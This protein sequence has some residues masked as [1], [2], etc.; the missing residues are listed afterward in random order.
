MRKVKQWVAALLLVALSMSNC[1]AASAESLPADTPTDSL[2]VSTAESM[3]PEKPEQETDAQSESSE[4]AQKTTTQSA[5]I[6][7]SVPAAGATYAVVIPE[8]L[9]LGTLDA[10]Q[11]FQQD[12]TVSVEIYNSDKPVT[13]TVSAEDSFSMMR[14]D[15]QDAVEQMLCY[16]AFET[17]VFH[18]SGQAAGRLTISKR[19]IA[20]AA[21]GRYAGT[22]QFT[23]SSN[24][25]EGGEVPSPDVSPQ[26]TA[27]P[28]P[29]AAPQPTITPKPT[30]APQPTI[31]PLPTASPL[32]TATP[33]PVDED[34][35]TED[36][37]YTA[38][39][40]MRKE[41]NFNE[42]SMCNKL[43]YPQVDI[44][45]KG[46]MATVTMYVI[47][48]VP[49]FAN[50]GTPL[51]NLSLTYNG[52]NYPVQVNDGSKVMKQFAAAPG[53]IAKAGEYS[54]TPLVVTLPIKALTDSINQAV[55]GRA[56]V[57]AVM[58][59]DVDFYVVFSDLVSTGGGKPTN[60]PASKKPSSYANNADT[61]S[62]QT[63]TLDDGEK[64]WYTSAVSMRRAD[65]F[66]KESMCDPLFF[67]KADIMYQGNTAE[68]TLY[69]ID[70]VPK[71]ADA[72]TPIKDVNFLYDEKAYTST[73][74][75]DQKQEKRFDAAS[76]FISQAGVYPATPIKVVLP[77][78]AIE[79][80]I[81]GK[82]KCSAY[83]N[84]VM[85]TTQ[86]FYVVLSDLEEGQPPADELAASSQSDTNQTEKKQE[87]QAVASELKSIRLHTKLFPQ[88]LIY[89]LFTAVILGGAFA[90]QW[91]RRR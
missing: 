9:H 89:V 12:Y 35:I 64:S 48:P 67:E 30:V 60:K 71:F 7:A 65:D 57:S 15:R 66:N 61:S 40:S 47:D 88:V 76:G 77:K 11:E 74:L 19:E 56:F 13:V 83:I 4:K 31:T 6:H 38:T 72:G 1:L 59:Q 44:E 29:T 63:L 14:T 51:R 62:K 90:V 91:F 86:E 8:G 26:P 33:K 36:G 68:L 3:I 58:K 81:D 73:V 17:A 42:I 53:F 37:H 39:V 34:S 78:Q 52:K 85:N 41:T 2:P 5:T 49:Q 24:K 55:R 10:N 45:R 16:N 50:E 80:S 69:V 28:K 25:Q 18:T 21:P 23:I 46:D 22:L 70:P 27:M 75:S 20:A 79:E 43:F 82:L 84:T 32:P 54:A 87:Q